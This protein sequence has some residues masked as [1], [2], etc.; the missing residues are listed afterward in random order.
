[1]RATDGKLGA[2]P[3]EAAGA[4]PQV[5]P[6]LLLDGAPACLGRLAVMTRDDLRKTHKKDLLFHQRTLE[7]PG[8]LKLVHAARQ[9]HYLVQ[10]TRS[11][12]QD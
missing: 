11:V 10:L 3:R 4:P 2:L 5:I 8:Q 12:I 9:P 7:L 1:V 6:N